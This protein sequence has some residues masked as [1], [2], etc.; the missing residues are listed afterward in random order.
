M[1]PPQSSDEFVSNAK[2]SLMF[3]KKHTEQVDESFK[4]VSKRMTDVLAP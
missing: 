2:R 1:T 3:M 4:T